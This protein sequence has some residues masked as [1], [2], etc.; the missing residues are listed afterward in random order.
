MII[1]EFVAWVPRA[2]L[3]LCIIVPSEVGAD[4]TPGVPTERLD[5]PTVCG[6]KIVSARRSFLPLEHLG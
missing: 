6:L 3:G 4:D 2:T 1:S 5:D